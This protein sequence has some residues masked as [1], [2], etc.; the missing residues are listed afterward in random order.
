MKSALSSFVA[1]LCLLAFFVSSAACMAAPMEIESA[2]AMHM[3]S[4]SGT[5]HACCPNQTSSGAHVSGAC[6][7][8]HHQPASPASTTE[9][10]QHSVP[11]FISFV[12][13]FPSGISSGISAANFNSVL[14]RP[15]PIIA[16]RI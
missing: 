4:M 15:S 5:M 1:S 2:H 16:L 9:W 7:T 11:H 12:I 6:C 14:P 10:Q 3:H 8:I 13:P